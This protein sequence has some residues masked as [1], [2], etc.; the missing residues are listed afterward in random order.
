MSTASDP[1]SVWQDYGDTEYGNWV[2]FLEHI[3]W[4]IYEDTEGRRETLKERQGLLDRIAVHD[5][6]VMG[7]VEAVWNAHL[8]DLMEF[9]VRLVGALFRTW[10]SDPSGFDDWVIQAKKLAGLDA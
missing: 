3:A 8:N 7:D 9:A 10:P 2:Q 4:S 5:D 6:V 1:I